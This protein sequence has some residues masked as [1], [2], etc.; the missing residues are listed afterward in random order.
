LWLFGRSVERNLG[1][2][3]FLL[4]YLLSGVSAAIVQVAVDPSSPAPMIGASGAIAGVLSAYVSLYPWRRIRTLVPIFIL[5][6][7]FSIP[8]FVIVF[9][10]FVLNL[11][12]G[13]GALKLRSQAQGGTAWWAH[14]GGFVAGL[15]L[16]RLLFP[17]QPPAPPRASGA[18]PTWDDGDDRARW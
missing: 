13:L 10:W 11:F 6:V 2:L 9:E 4:L 16:V 8:A 18:R 1:S 17:D 5:P 12:Q 14:I 15:V 3:R 7:V